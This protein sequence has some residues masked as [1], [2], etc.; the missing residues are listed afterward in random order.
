MPTPTTTRSLLLKS[1]DGARRDADATGA[2]LLNAA[3]F[4][5]YVLAVAGTVDAA[6][7]L[8]PAAEGSVYYARVRSCLDTVEQDERE[9]TRERVS[10]A[11]TTTL[12]DLLGQVPA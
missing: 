1:W 10:A 12:E 3:S 9:A 6:R 2:I 11:V 8:I 7:A 5:G 4:A